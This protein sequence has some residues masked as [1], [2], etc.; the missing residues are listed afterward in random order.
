M[1]TKFIFLLALI[2]TINL[3]TAQETATD[4]LVKRDGTVILV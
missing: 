2:F 4:K 1:Y 3:L